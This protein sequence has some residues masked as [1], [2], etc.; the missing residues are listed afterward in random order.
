VI[1]DAYNSNPDGA[2]AALEVLEAMPGGKKI[3][4]TPGM[5]ELG[6]EQY[7]ANAEFGR[8]AAE[9][10]DVVIAVAT[11][12][13]DALLEGAE[14][15]GAP[16]KVIAVASLAEATHRLTGLVASGDVVLFENDLPDQY[17]G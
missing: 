4:I 7:E 2:A 15:A 11:V 14:R 13:R 17:E 1:D 16:Q 3:V 10:A 12:N 8:R 6:T 9:V 5:V